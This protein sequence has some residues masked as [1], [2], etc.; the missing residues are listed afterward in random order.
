[1]K[2]EL[3]RKKIE[4]NYRQK[5]MVIE[6]DLNQRTEEISK[7]VK[8]LSQSIK[9]SCMISEQDLFQLKI[10]INTLIEYKS[11]MKESE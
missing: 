8:N 5:I 7:I 2:I 9:T 10:S 4:I 1:M 11:L 6:D 3:I